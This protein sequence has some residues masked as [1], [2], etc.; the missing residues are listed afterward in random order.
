M[1]LHVDSLLIM[2]MVTYI[3]IATCVS[4]HASA[5]ALN[6]S[7]WVQSRVHNTVELVYYGYLGI[8]HKWPDYQCVLIFQA[9]LY[10][11]LHHLGP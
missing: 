5:N 4:Y 1:Y 6:M 7:L 11:M 2:V 3:Y 8:S 9:S 10:D